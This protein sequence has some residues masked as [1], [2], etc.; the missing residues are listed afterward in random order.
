MDTETTKKRINDMP[1]DQ[2]FGSY[3]L[4]GERYYNPGLWQHLCHL[5]TTL[6]RRGDGCMLLSDK[7]RLNFIWSKEKREDA[8]PK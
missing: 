5:N 8:Y 6:A 7:V 1:A 4:T 3:D 2:W